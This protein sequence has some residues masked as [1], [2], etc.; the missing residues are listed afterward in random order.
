MNNTSFLI[1]PVKNGKSTHFTK[2]FRSC[3]HCS[4]LVVFFLFMLNLNCSL[5]SPSLL[6]F[7]YRKR[8]TDEK[9]A[10]A[11]TS[12]IFFSEKTHVTAVISAYISK[13]ITHVVFMYYTYLNFFHGVSA[14]SL[15]LTSKKQNLDFA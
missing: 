3:L 12:I 5:V 6:T 2:S 10:L 15:S 14:A 9:K 1:F 4:G 8:S 13:R 7:C 11:T